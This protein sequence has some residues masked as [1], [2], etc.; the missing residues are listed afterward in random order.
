MRR[1]SF[2]L[3]PDDNAVTPGPLGLIQ[4]SVGDSQHLLP[5]LAVIGKHPDANGYRDGSD[6]P[7]LV[8][9]LEILHL[10]AELFGALQDRSLRGRSHD[11]HELFAAIAR[12]D[13]LA[14]RSGQHVLAYRAQHRIPRR[15]AERVV[16]ALE[17]VDVDHQHAEGLAAAPSA[18][19]FPAE[20]LFE[21]A[22]V[23]EA[24]PPPL[25]NPIVQAEGLLRPFLLPPSPPFFFL[26]PP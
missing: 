19:F 2:H 7:A 3:V 20:R 13:I 23:I 22:A 12:D 6:A 4:G 14:P 16:E 15:V 1:S 25:P 18:A 10:P 17:V 21:V 8:L 24:R 11:Q 5:T 9:D 26:V